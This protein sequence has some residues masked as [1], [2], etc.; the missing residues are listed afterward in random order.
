MG[1]TVIAAKSYVRYLLKAFKPEDDVFFMD[2]KEAMEAF[3]GKSSQE[4]LLYVYMNQGQKNFSLSKR[5]LECA[6]SL[7]DSEEK[8]PDYVFLKNIRSGLKEHGLIKEDS[9]QQELLK[10]REIY[11]FSLGNRDSGLEE[12]FIDRGIKFQYLEAKEIKDDSPKR[13]VEVYPEFKIEAEEAINRIGK[14]ISEDQ[15]QASDIGV[16]CKKELLPFLSLLGLESGIQLKYEDVSLINLSI[17]D[18]DLALINK[19]ESDKI[20]LQTVSEDTGLNMAQKAFYDR[21][22]QLK[23]DGLEGKEGYSEFL[24]EEMKDFVFSKKVSSC[25]EGIALSHDFSS[26]IG[27]KAVLFLGF[28][29]DVPNQSRDNSYLNDSQKEKWTYLKKS[30]EINAEAEGKII[31]GLNVS[32]QAFLSHSLFA[33]YLGYK[34]QSRFT[35]AERIGKEEEF[36]PADVRYVSEGD[37]FILSCLNGD[38]SSYGETSS[39]FE[40]LSAGKKARKEYKP[41]NAALS[42]PVPDVKDFSLSFS[43]MTD[44][45]R[46]PYSFLLKR[47]YR[48]PESSFKDDFSIYNGTLAHKVLEMSFDHEE[49]SYE[50]ALQESGITPRS[51]RDSFYFHKTYEAMKTVYNTVRRFMEFIYFDGVETERRFINNNYELP[52]KGSI[53]ALFSSPVG[54]AVLDYKTGSHAFNYDDSYN[55]FDMQLPFYALTARDFEEEKGKSLFGFYFVQVENE[56]VLFDFA[57][58]VTVT[59]FSLLGKNGDYL[60]LSDKDKKS[61]KDYLTFKFSNKDLSFEALEEKIPST[62]KEIIS[63]V[64]NGSFPVKAKKYVNASGDDIPGGDQCRYCPY[65][66][67]CYKNAYDPHQFEEIHKLN[68]KKDEAAKDGEDE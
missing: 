45:A 49:L 32:K 14:L 16:C 51:F 39:Y 30:Y 66:D 50:K 3:L 1:K 6:L 46:C 53:D 17:I 64:E 18:K 27:K 62:I 33:S 2:E 54:F 21:L 38:Y 67:C 15:I 7:K 20:G 59:G 5:L 36:K 63:G 19:G 13:T 26:L 29:E 10:G 9:L 12:L 4:A 65:Q 37:D 42:C 8:N 55:G 11:I 43:S 35:A 56:N 47:V 25:Q 34:D 22:S 28:D 61:F 58:P 40:R 57:N 41:E 68:E 60:I 23:E 24:Y 48:I 44:Y 31:A 52:I